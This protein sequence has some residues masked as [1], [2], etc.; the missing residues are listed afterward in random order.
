MRVVSATE[1]FPGSVHEAE[2]VWYD[3]AKWP[4][5]VDGL[6]RVE[7]VGSGWPAVGGSVTWQSHPAGR[8][9][10]VERV[11]AYE[12]LSG[13]TLEVEDDSITGTQS[14]DFT[15]EGESVAV[16]LAFC[17]E[18][19]ER[20]IATP[21][22]DLLFIRR[23]FKSSIELTLHRFGLELAAARTPGDR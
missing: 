11:V 14:V 19:T 12:P 2:T 22:I 1:T 13:Q 15:P 4:G 5:W 10:V 3:T 8:G 20:S 9:R 17:Y 18:I 21:L 7:A 23:A 16:E 6:D